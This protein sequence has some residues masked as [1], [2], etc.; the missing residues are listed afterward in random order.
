MS[1]A[2]RDQVDARSRVGADRLERDAAGDLEQARGAACRQS[3]RLGDARP[4]PASGVM[5]SSSTTSAPA[6]TASATWSSAVALDVDRA[7]PATGR[8]AGARPRRC[9]APAR[10]LSLTSTQSDRLPRWLRPP[11]ARTAA[12][13]SARRPGRASC[14]C[15][16][17]APPRRAA[18]ASTKRGGERGDARQV[19]EEV[20]RGALAGE[21]RARADPTTVPIDRARL[22]R[23]AVAARPRHLDRR[24]RP[25]ANASVAHSGARE[26]AR[27]RATIRGRGASWPGEQRRG[28]VA[29]RGEVLGQRHAPPRRARRGRGRL[30]RSDASGGSVTVPRRRSTSRCALARGRSSG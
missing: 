4:R 16:R 20:E 24:R 30:A 26:H 15:P 14:G 22:D 28:E 5:L 2:D 6:A 18:A 3:L 8:G 11:P 21:D 10:W 19:A 7:A 17:P 9:R 23:V 25:G 27:P 12:F 1:R 29:E 13:S